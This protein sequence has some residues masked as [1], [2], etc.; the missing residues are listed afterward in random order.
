MHVA[1]LT[2]ILLTLH[3]LLPSPVF[4]LPRLFTSANRED[5]M[6]RIKF[7]AVAIA[8]LLS[9]VMSST[10]ADMLSN[11]H[12]RGAIRIGVR[13]DA[14][15]WAFLDSN[16]QSQGMEIDIG[17]EIAHR[18]GVSFVPVIVSPANSIPFLDQ[19]RVDIILATLSD[20]IT[21]PKKP[22]RT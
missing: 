19:G 15:P 2:K 13:A 17:H 7:L 16:G 18:L 8:L 10:Y 12:A 20:T 14:K 6:R 9:S 11:I 5:R 4:F 3:G 22:E 1:K 21:R